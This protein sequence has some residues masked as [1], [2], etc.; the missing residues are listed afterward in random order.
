MVDTSVTY[1][2]TF[3]QSVTGV[4]ATALILCAVF[5]FARMFGIT[6][7]YHRYFAH[8]SYKAGRIVQ[9][10]EQLL[11][12]LTPRKPKP[13]CRRAVFELQQNRV[14]VAFLQRRDGGHSLEGRPHRLGLLDH[15]VEQDRKSVV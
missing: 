13:Q 5:Y 10:V 11:V 7:G 2:V 4:D 15:P 9:F 8:R 14:G 1:T 12:G 6:A 3:D